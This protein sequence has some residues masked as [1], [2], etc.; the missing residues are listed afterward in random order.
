M[1]KFE[2]KQYF[3]EEEKPTG[4]GPEKI[5]ISE[6][7]WQTLKII[8]QRVGGDFRM[9]VRLGEPGGGSFFNPEDGSITFDPLDIKENPDLAK[10]VAG[11]EGSHR[12]INPHP[13]ELGLPPEKIRELYSQIGFG[14]LQNVIE[15][16][17]IN[18]WMVKRFPGLEPY[19][20]KFYN[21]QFKEEN[22][23]LS[24]PEV[25]KVAFQLGYCPKFAQYGSEII[26]DW[27]QG[28]FSKNLDPAVEKALQ[29][30]IEYAR[31]SRTT[32][33]NPEKSERKEIIQ[34]AQERFKINTEYIW[35]EVKKLV[36]MD[37]HTEE[38]RQ[39]LKEFRQKQKELE[40]KIKEMEQAQK[41]GNKERQEELQKEIERL[42]KELDPFNSLPEDVKKEIQEQIDKAIREAAE[43]LNKEIEEKQRQIEEA[44]KRQEELEKE[45]QDLEEKAKSA[46]GKEKEELEKQ[47]Q[48]KK[49]E[50]LAQEMKQ[51]QA[52]KELEEIQKALDEIQSGEEMP[53]PEDKLSEKTKQELEKLF[54][55]LPRQKREELKDK[56]QKQL[57]DFEDTIN[58][59]LEGKLNE[60]KPESHRERREREKERREREKAERE[61]AKKSEEARIERERIKKEL[62]RMRRERMTP[63]ERARAE[64]VGLIDD[65]YYR[66]RRIL[67]PEEYGGE[68]A[69]YPAGQKLDIT[70]A[71]QA[72]KD[73]LQK[74]KLWIRETAPERKDY[75]FWH[76]VD[77]SGSMAGKKIEETFKGFIVV[78]EAID[79]IENL[80][81]D[82]INIR[83]GITGF[84]NRIFP[85][86]DPNERFTKQVEDRLS[87][88]PERT[89]DSD[90][91]TNTY[92]ATLFALEALK[93]V[94][95]ETGN[96]LL[97]FSDGEPNYDVR[98]KLKNLLKKG[99]EE[100]KKLKIKV[101]L[102]WLGEEENQEKL[103][104]LV[105][106]Y[107]YDFGLV[108]PAVKP[109][110]GKSFSEALADLLEDIV[111]NPE[112]Y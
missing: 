84:H 41:E 12:A 103:Q 8:A 6:E 44:R 99:K 55:K 77:L 4:R 58:K 15:D 13:K 40:Q 73:I 102:I 104:E 51:K 110:K 57:E 52:E 108:M 20:E 82:I 79:R 75:C 21:E 24:T 91:G 101:G 18:D 2:I 60:D 63:Y 112:K 62:E 16:P 94:W 107:G 68:E 50:K 46:Q 53:Y 9:E 42:E 45:I 83:Q 98:D 90:A 111:K 74:Q 67:K 48:E 7:D 105:K 85:Y 65:L 10:F 27:H 31:K 59:E 26:R 19:T 71:M 17:A 38:K 49:A 64:V 66:L 37:L 106:E 96:F 76:L 69:G 35:P 36:E 1:R 80:N 39:M 88:M 109:E 56:A 22:A 93:K 29:R 100:R 70:R 81:S 87:G 33:P 25:Q 3:P 78:G 72:E 11:H 32:I 89:Q 34:T 97:T 86:K 28:R 61:A 95:G 5:E 47:I 23:V 54:D 30:T 43:K 92:S 14:Y